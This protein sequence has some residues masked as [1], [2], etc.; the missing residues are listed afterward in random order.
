MVEER[1]ISE[2][3]KLFKIY[4]KKEEEEEEME[5]NKDDLFHK[6]PKSEEFPYDTNLQKNIMKSISKTFPI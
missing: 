5:M 2:I 3:V 1:G 4:W 6:V